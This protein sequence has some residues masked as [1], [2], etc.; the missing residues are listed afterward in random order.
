VKP[1]T[2]ARAAAAAESWKVEEAPLL[3]VVAEAAALESVREAEVDIEPLLEEVLM[4]LE[5]DLES[6]EDR[7]SLDAAEEL[8]PYVLRSALYQQNARVLLLTLRYQWRTQWSWCQGREL[9]LQLHSYSPS[10]RQRRPCDHLISKAWT[11]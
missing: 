6:E 3:E 1:A 9:L 5:E 11:I 4:S 8:F 10:K 7:E 2:P